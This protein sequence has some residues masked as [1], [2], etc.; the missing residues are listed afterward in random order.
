M[1]LTPT[2]AQIKRLPSTGTHPSRRRVVLS[3]WRPSGCAHSVRRCHVLRCVASVALIGL[4]NCCWRCSS[5]V[6]VAA[7]GAVVGAG[8]VSVAC[9]RHGWMHSFRRSRFSSACCRVERRC[10]CCELEWRWSCWCRRLRLCQGYGLIGRKLH[11]LCW[12][13]RILWR[14]PVVFLG[15]VETVRFALAAI[16]I[17]LRWCL[18]R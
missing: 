14:V 13:V 10:I 12:L 3:F 8:W 7:A 16:E 4:G 11:R 17:I 9:C 15:G 1:R 6:D 5:P 2:S 18:H